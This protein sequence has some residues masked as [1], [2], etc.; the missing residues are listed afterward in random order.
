MKKTLVIML[1][2]SISV[3]GGGCAG[4]WADQGEAAKSTARAREIAAQAAQD[5]ARAAV[6]EAQ[7]TGALAKSQAEALDRTI[8]ALVDLSTVDDKYAMIFAGFLLLVL[9]GIG[10]GVFI[11]LSSRTNP[12]PVQPNKPYGML[13]ET[14]NGIVP[15]VQKPEETVHQFYLRVM[16]TK[17]ELGVE[18][19]PKLL[20]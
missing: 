5:N 18:N 11:L 9:V 2:V 16:R 14:R 13:I 20:E 10:I 7:S 6:I 19:V 17:A 3:L 15:L 1:L 4:F 12:G 8:V